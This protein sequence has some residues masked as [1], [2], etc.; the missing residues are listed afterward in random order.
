MTAALVYLAPRSATL[1]TDGMMTGPNGAMV[2]AKQKVQ[3]AAHQSAAFVGRGPDMFGAL[4][5]VAVAQ[6]Q[7]SFDDLARAFP[8]QVVG[9]HRAM[10]AALQAGHSV[11]ADPATIDGVL[12]GIDGSGR[13][14]GIC[15]SSYE[16]DGHPPW[17]AKALT[18]AVLPS[19]AQ[20]R[21]TPDDIQPSL[22]FASP[23]PASM[24]FDLA[25]SSVKPWEPCPDV[26][27]HGRRIM[28]AQ[29]SSGVVGGFCQM[30]TV[31]ADSIA[32]E[33]IERWPS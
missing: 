33:I 27:E 31:S 12:V 30:T 21:F 23:W 15:V 10:M 20:L 7:G 29:R 16:D 13:A 5:A 9:A 2:A 24:D 4:L 28:R 11:A 25:V 32:T 22:A 6:V 17:T 8:E 26:R 1:F 3:I 14:K 18:P 19:A